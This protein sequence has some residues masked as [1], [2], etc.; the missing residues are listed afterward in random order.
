[1]VHTVWNY[2]RIITVCPYFTAHSYNQ[3]KSY[4]S[5]TN[6]SS[7]NVLAAQPTISIQKVM[8]AQPTIYPPKKFWQLNQLSAF[9]K[10]WQLN[11]QYIQPKNS[12]LTAEPIISP[13]KKLWQL[14]QQYI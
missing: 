2:Y 6:I 11:Q 13:V 12:V 8:V 3:P 10:L 4:D 14:N 7:Q 9:K 5:L 1:M